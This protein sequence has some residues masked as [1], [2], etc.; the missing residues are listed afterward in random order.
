MFFHNLCC[1]NSNDLYNQHWNWCL[2]S[3]FFGTLKIDITRVKLVPVLSGIAFKQQ[4]NECN[5]FER[6]NWKSQTN[7]DQKSDALFLQ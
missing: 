1:L 5:S 2:F 7:R 4:F 3:L 6:I